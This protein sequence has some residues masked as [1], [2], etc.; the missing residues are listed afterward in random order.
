MGEPDMQ[1]IRDRV[2]IMDLAARYAYLLDYRPDRTDELTE[3]F[4]PDAVFMLPNQGIVYEGRGAIR[5]AMARVHQ[6]KRQ[7]HHF[8]SNHVIDLAGDRAA[9]HL[10]YNEFLLL[11]EK[12]HNYSQG[13]YEDEYER[14]DG[15]WRF[16]S[17]RVHIPDES[18][19]LMTSQ[20]MQAAGAA[21]VQTFSST[22]EQLD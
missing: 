2:M 13:R 10:H 11:P 15:I 14:R 17:R 21:V 18:F 22:R 8:T 16:R 19:R 9:G 12:V 20:E 3:L 1:E 4:L 7:L 5:E 6:A